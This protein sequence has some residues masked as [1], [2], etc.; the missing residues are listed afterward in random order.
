MGG[1]LSHTI[2]CEDAPSH[3]E[4]DSLLTAQRIQPGQD[5]TRELQVVALV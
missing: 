5:G 2:G 4:A 3:A 1:D